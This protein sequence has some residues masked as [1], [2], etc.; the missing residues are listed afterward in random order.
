MSIRN[1][2]K[3]LER[4]MASQKYI[5]QQDQ[6]ELLKVFIEIETV[7]NGRPPTD[8]EIEAERQRLA[9]PI[10]KLSHKEWQQNLD[11]VER[12]FD[13]AARSENNELRKPDYEKMA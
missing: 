13:E 10:K 8:E 7:F 3:K 2:V 6:K 9:Q 4:K 11:E 12:L 1:R 5:S